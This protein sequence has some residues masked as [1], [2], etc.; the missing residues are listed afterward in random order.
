MET[1]RRGNES[2]QWDRD[3]IKQLRMDSG[4]VRCRLLEPIVRDD[5]NEDVVTIRSLF[6]EKKRNH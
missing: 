1:H 6:L 3:G 4:A 5:D 2:K